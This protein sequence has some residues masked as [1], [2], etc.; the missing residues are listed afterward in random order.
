MY[1]HQTIQSSDHIACRPYILQS[2]DTVDYTVC[3]PYILLLPI[4]SVDH[5]DS[6]Q[7]M[8][9]YKSYVLLTILSLFADHTIFN[10]RNVQAADHTNA[11]HTV[12]RIFSLQILQT[13]QYAD[14]NNDS[15]KTRTVSL[16][17]HG[18]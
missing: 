4:Q 11:E 17:C 12:F 2:I 7:T 15:L 6:L 1:D 5:T 3:I 10:L 16:P 8:A 9:V 14:N 13:I 18:E